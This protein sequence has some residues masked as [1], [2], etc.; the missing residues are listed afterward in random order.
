MKTLAQIYNE[1]EGEWMDT[2]HGTKAEE[3]TFLQEAALKIYL[4]QLD[5]TKLNQKD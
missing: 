4:K 5:E 2:F 3:R 1:L